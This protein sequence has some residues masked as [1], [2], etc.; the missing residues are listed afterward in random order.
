[1]ISTEKHL[2]DLFCLVS[3]ICYKSQVVNGIENGQYWHHK[4]GIIVSR[5]S[6]SIFSLKFVHGPSN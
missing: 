4:N 5:N 6:F 3:L 1:M 2:N